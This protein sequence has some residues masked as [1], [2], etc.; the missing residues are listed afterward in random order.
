MRPEQRVLRA[1]TAAV[2]GVALALSG[3]GG[4]EGMSGSADSSTS[5][6]VDLDQVQV[7]IA[8]HDL[9]AGTAFDRALE[10]G[11]IMLAA[12]PASEVQEGASDDPDA[13]RGAVVVEPIGQGEQITPEGVNDDPAVA[14]L[15]IPPGRIAIT[16]EVARPLGAVMPG[17]LVRLRIVKPG[18]TRD[19][20]PRDILVLAA[21]E[22]R[23]AQGTVGL[24]T[25]AVSR[26]EAEKLRF[27]DK[28][29]EV[30]SGA[31]TAEVAG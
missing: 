15:P 1:A 20:L 16:I 14:T 21:G 13:F 28:L 17:A 25:V 10:N 22:T 8:A 18:S 6:T 9:A 26:K 19:V 23:L 31:L 5:P 11:D 27:A 29:A 3:C 2:C 30:T 7:L 24:L 12:V 4:D